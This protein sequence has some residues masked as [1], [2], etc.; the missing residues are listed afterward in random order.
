MI[1]TKELRVSVQLKKAWKDAIAPVAE[2]ALADF[3]TWPL[4]ERVGEPWPDA[5]ARFV[6]AASVAAVVKGLKSDLTRK[7]EEASNPGLRE[8][9]FNLSTLLNLRQQ[10]FWQVWNR[11]EDQIVSKAETALAALTK[12]LKWKPDKKEQG[13]WLY[14]PNAH[15]MQH[16]WEKLHSQA[17]EAPFEEHFLT[18]FRAG[19][20]PAGLQGEDWKTCRFLFF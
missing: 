8:M 17:V 14:P 15:V 16:V 18:I 1:R 7:L 4:Y 10:H 5:P 20:V 12:R 3:R 19:H 11:V 6:R 9:Y 2:A 13:L